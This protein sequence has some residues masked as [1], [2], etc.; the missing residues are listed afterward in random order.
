MAFDVLQLI[1]SIVICE[2]IG[3]LG[4]ALTAR[5]I[6]TWYK[7]LRK[8]SFNPPN[9]IFAPV[10]TVLYLMMGISLYLVWNAGA[11]QLAIV[12][13]GAQLLANFLWSLLFFGAHKP[14][15][16]FIDI[17]VMWLLILA[18]IL[19]FYPVSPLAAYLLIPYLLWVGFASALNY[20]IVVLNK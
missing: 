7:K 6:P 3:L 16:A 10:W 13:F 2:G 17:I 19:V 18:T 8:P 15:L 5:S 20:E 14:L 11:P 12:L 9:Q 4:G 1:V